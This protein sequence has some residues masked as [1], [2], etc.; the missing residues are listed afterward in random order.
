MR[1]ALLRTL[2]FLVALLIGSV[3]QAS[4]PGRVVAVGDLHGDH[5]AFREITQAA[6]LVDEEGDWIGGEAVLVQLGDVTDRGPDSLKIIRDLQR[7]EEQAEDAGGDVIALVGNHEAM[8]VIGDLRYVHPGEYDAFADRRSN[9]KRKAFWRRNKEAIIAAMKERFPEGNE[10]QWRAKWEEEHPRGWIEHRLAWQPGGELA[11]WYATKL[12]I[13]KIG[14]TIFVHGGISTSVAEQGI[15]AT[16]AAIMAGLSDLTVAA[17]LEAQDGPLW[18]RGNLERFHGERPVEAVRAE[19]ETVLSTLDATRLVVA[20]TPRIA[21]IDA[22]HDGRLVRI[23]TGISDHY[24]GRLAFLEIVDGMP[25]AIEQ[26]D[27]GNWVRRALPE[28]D[29]E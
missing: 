29:G 12:A 21:G 6:N 17:P 9:S 27:A 4:G 14:D 24:G 23:D 10:K 22:P 2:L 28:G 25:F 8:N 13:A 7:L 11:E 19:L 18:Y 3:A 20:H 15:D 5:E 26:D 16:N 1:M